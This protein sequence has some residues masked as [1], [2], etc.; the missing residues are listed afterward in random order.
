MSIRGDR[1][2]VN[3]TGETDGLRDTR[4]P[5]HPYHSVAQIF[6]VG[7]YDAPLTKQSPLSTHAAPTSSP[8]PQEGTGPPA[9]TPRRPRA[10]RT[11]P[12][13]PD[14]DRKTGQSSAVRR[15]PQTPATSPDELKTPLARGPCPPRR[16]RTQRPPPVPPSSSTRTKTTASKPPWLTHHDLSSLTDAGTCLP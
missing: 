2:S 1:V 14:A 12:S 6:Q 8:L 10:W 15:G 9:R 5:V 13:P 11:R 16:P 4:R 3:Q 7:E